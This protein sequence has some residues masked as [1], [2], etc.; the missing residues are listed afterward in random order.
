MRVA[1]AGATGYVGGELL[2]LLVQRPDIEIGAL[3]GNASVGTLLGEHHRHLRR[4]A[5]RK[6]EATD[7]ATLLDHDVVLMALPSGSSG[8]LVS[9]LDPEQVLIDCGADHRLASEDAWRRYY[10][11]EYLGQWSYGLPEVGDN[12]AALVNSRQ[13]AVPGCYPTA[14][15]LALAPALAAGLVEPDVVV[16]A[17]SGTSGAG[18]VLRHDLSATE[19]I[20]S[21]VPYGVGGV[22]RHTPEIAQN[23]SEVAGRPVSV[24]FT[25][26]LVPIP[27]GLV[28]V[29]SARL[30][31]TST[32]TTEV[33]RVYEQAYG[34]EV[35]VDL[36]AV[37]AWPTT[38]VVVGSNAAHVQC[39]IDSTSGR[40]VAVCAI[41]N[42]GKGAAGAAVQCM[43]LALGLDEDLGLSV[44]GIAP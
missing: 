39:T 33:R 8:E 22:H 13:I 12:R 20:G 11:G 5:D 9:G 3:T 34:P 26:V 1:V 37:D 27:R 17:A 18:K 44:D 38:A 23:L 36:L 40:M 4:V 10:G 25:P 7:P 19:M 30:R 29:C 31:D 43:N 41:D 16:N 28:A 15:T 24:S 14:A 21:V 35:F 42:L 32:S 2:R 6:V